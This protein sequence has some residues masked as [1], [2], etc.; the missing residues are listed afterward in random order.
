MVNQEQ[1]P[2]FRNPGERIGHENRERV[3]HLLLTKPGIKHVEISKLLNLNPVAVGKH[4][5]RIR[6][7]WS[8]Q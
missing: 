7:E 1:E 5:A 8:D 3:R 4:V 2:V 6:K